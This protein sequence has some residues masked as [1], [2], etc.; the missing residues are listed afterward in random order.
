MKLYVGV[1]LHE[2]PSTECLRSLLELEGEELSS[3]LE[4][5]D[6]EELYSKTNQYFVPEE[7]VKL[8]LEEMLV[9]H[10]F[11][12]LLLLPPES[13]NDVHKTGDALN[14]ENVKVFEVVPGEPLLSLFTNNLLGHVPV[15][16][17]PMY[18]GVIELDGVSDCAM[19]LVP[20]WNVDLW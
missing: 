2:E 15:N 10:V 11:S 18:V 6:G 16:P 1:L 17:T 14:V 12:T 4:S 20:L 3:V 9:V 7:S 13:F 19:Y 8:E 5:K